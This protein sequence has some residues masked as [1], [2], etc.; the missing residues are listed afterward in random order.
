MYFLMLSIACSQSGA[1]GE[2]AT[3]AVEAPAEEVVWATWNEGSASSADVA[4]SVATE[5]AQL[6]S[7]YLMNRYQLETQAAGQY[8]MEKI[9]E[10]A[11]AEKG[12][13]IEGLLRDA[14]ESSVTRPSDEEIAAF[15]PRIRDRVG[16]AP[17]EEVKELIANLIMDQQRSN[18]AQAFVGQLGEEHGLT[19]TVP[20]PDLPRMEVSVDDDPYLGPADAPITIVEFAEFEC[21]YCGRAQE[22]VNRV[23][24]EYEGQVRFVFRDFPLGFHARAIPTALAANCAGEQGKFWEMHARLLSDQQRLDDAT[25]L[26]YATELELDLAAWNACRENPA[27]TAEIQADQ[28]A[29]AELGVT[30]TP[31]FFINGVFLSGALPFDTFKQI[32]DRDLE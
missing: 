9:L 1:T 25:L 28:A 32:I 30:G 31:A 20:F 15:Y 26:S 19:T 3:P 12:T 17:L 16:G 18:G 5:L 14:V 13:D 24:T 7:E 29:G 4:G 8:A 22:T 23:L 27:M 11:A 10:A 6:E 2:P 21:G